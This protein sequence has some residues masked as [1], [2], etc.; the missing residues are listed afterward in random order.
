MVARHPLGKGGMKSKISALTA[1]TGETQKPEQ[2]CDL[3]AT[4]TTESN[5]RR[6]AR[7]R[8]FRVSKYRRGYDDAFAATHWAKGSA[9][10]WD[11]DL[12]ELEAFID[13]QPLGQT[14]GRHWRLD[15]KRGGSQ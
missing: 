6:K 3:P 8:G 2:K 13:K 9:D 11:A 15:S 7:R 4:H 5:I 10:I 14:E 1:N 12:G